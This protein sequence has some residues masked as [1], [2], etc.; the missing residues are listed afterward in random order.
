VLITGETGA[1]KEVAARAVHTATAATMGRRGEFVAVN[2]AALPDT[3][4]ESELFGHVRGAFTGAESARAGAFELAANGTLFLDEIGDAP[5]SL[6]A[7]LL[8]AI[9]S[10]A[11]TRIGC[12]KPVETSC[13]IVCATNVDLS[14][15]VADG[16][17]R[18]DL[19]Y[20]IDV[21]RL[22]VPPLRER[23]DFEQ[24]AASVLA[25]VNE[26]MGTNLRISDWGS[27]RYRMWPG[28]VRE[29]RNA[30]TR[31]AVLGETPSEGAK[32]E[33][34]F[35]RGEKHESAARIFEALNKHGGN[36]AAAARELG[37]NRTTLVE[38]MRRH[39]ATS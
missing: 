32:H 18:A 31:A 28:N 2:C 22:R 11:V 39:A 9:D 26:E 14:K 13:R 19:L 23:E 20:R 21:L 30:L 5:R 1:G 35:I 4:A 3:L 29:L 15:A 36:K 38:R 37:M 12:G 17:F 10:G 7:K 16:K 33:S 8:R 34:D 24:V 6:Q 27:Y 25:R